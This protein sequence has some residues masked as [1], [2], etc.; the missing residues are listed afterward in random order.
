MTKKQ[1]CG[2]GS[3]TRN[4]IDDPPLTSAQVHEEPPVFIVHNQLSA[5][6][7]EALIAAATDG[8]LPELQYD[9]VKNMPKPRTMVPPT[10]T[11]PPAPTHHCHYHHYRAHPTTHPSTPITATTAATAT[12]SPL[13]QAVLLNT[14]RLW[15]L[16]LMVVAGAA[17]DVWHFGGPAVV[18]AGGSA[19]ALLQVMAL[20]TV[21]WS[22]AVG[23]LLAATHLAMR[24]A[25][26]GRVFTG[27][28]WTTKNL[29]QCDNSSGGNGCGGSSRDGGS[30]SCAAA[31]PAAVATER[32]IRATAR[33]LGTPASH[34][35]P[36]T[37]TR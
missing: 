34:L 23:A 30:S 10:P 11:H 12:L 3:S 33:L 15:P 14:H 16:A 37:V 1:P 24:Q 4:T 26:G 18:A 27:T 17:F 13:P 36:P 32:F 29:F 5:E 2:R 20:A 19:E 25:I 9:Q 6:D 7:C 22:A 31:A 21:R 35:E 8:V 28:K